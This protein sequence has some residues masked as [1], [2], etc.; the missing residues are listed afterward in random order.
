MLRVPSGT[1]SEICD[2]VQGEAW[3]GTTHCW[4]REQVMG[5]ERGAARPAQRAQPRQAGHTLRHRQR[6]PYATSRE[7]ELGPQVDPQNGKTR[8]TWLTWGRTAHDRKS[9]GRR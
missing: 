5:V 4:L 7:H 8:L 2:G 1:Q 3:K 6:A 9:W